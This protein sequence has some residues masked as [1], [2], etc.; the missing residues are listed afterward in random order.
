MQ[1]FYR[2]STD[3][4]DIPALE[5]PNCG[6]SKCSLEKWFELYENILPTKTYDEECKLSDGQTLPK[7]ENPEHFKIKT[8]A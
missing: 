8:I 6:S 4:A 2:N 1:L 5:I 7:Y 3:S